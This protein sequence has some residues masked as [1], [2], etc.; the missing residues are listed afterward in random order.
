MTISVAPIS[1]NTVQYHSIMYY[2]IW[3]IY[4]NANAPRLD[5]V[6]T[7]R[8]FMLSYGL[9]LK[10]SEH[11]NKETE[12]PFEICFLHVFPVGKC[13]DNEWFWQSLALHSS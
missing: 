13:S 6:L 1:C 2:S 4:D 3:H 10:G 9:L 5:V 11:N 12:T 8:K 7:K